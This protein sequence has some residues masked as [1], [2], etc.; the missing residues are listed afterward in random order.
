MRRGRRASYAI[1]GLIISFIKH[2]I[3]SSIYLLIVL[4]FFLSIKPGCAAYSIYLTV[5][6]L[7]PLIGLYI[8]YHFI[9][10]SK[11]E[12]TNFNPTNIKSSSS[13]RS[14]RKNRKPTGRTRP[15]KVCRVCRKRFTP[16]KSYYHTCP[17]CY[18]YN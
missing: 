12:T 8:Y 5:F 11:V 16:K 14:P 7:I 13:R 3:E 10:P 2:P 9:K 15:T 6:I 1:G 17:D 18:K 4:I